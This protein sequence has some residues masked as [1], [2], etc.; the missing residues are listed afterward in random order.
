MANRQFT[1]SETELRLL[2]QAETLANDPQEL[3]RLRAVRMY[4]S[5]YPVSEISNLTGCSWRSLMD[6]CRTYRKQG[7]TGLK[8]KWQ[9]NNALRLSREQRAELKLRIQYHHPDQVIP[10]DVR[11]SYGPIW[12]VSDLQY[13]ITQW[14]GITY[15][16]KASYL[17]IL[18]EV[19]IQNS[20]L[21]S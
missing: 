17:A 12:T 4:G 11:F 14:Y 13:V 21:D 1:L 18:R 3:K 5:G 7:A 9:G 8:S 16:S 19:G 15:R 10:P 20:K 2:R 6:W